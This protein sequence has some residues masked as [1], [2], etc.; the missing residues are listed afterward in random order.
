[1]TNRRLISLIE[2]LNK[3]KT[4]GL[5]HLRP[6][7]ELVDFAKVW[8]EKPKPTDNI[9]FPD[10]A[11]KFYF[12]KNQEGEYVATVLDMTRDLHWLVLNRHRGKG[13][14][15]NALTK[16]ILPHLFQDR[17]E[18]RVTIDE[19]QIGHKNF[20]ASENVALKVG[21]VETIDKE[22]YKEFTLTNE[23]Y[24]SCDYIGGRNTEVSEERINELKKK[25]NYLSRSLWVIQT[26]VEMTLGDFDYAE[27]LYELVREIKKH[28]LRLEDAWWDSK[29]QTE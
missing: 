4:N 14:L 13:H 19:I 25:I 7:T 11:Y 29:E 20:K 28:T 24:K 10:C 15:T 2:R 8:T 17:E 18:Q 22:Y 6:L 9:S 16:T 1:M 21:F 12:I 27:E 5:I 3:G 23:N 26:E